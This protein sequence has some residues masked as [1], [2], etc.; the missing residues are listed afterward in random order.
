MVAS[1]F[2]PRFVPIDFLL[3]ASCLWPARATQPVAHG[4]RPAAHAA[5][6][7]TQAESRVLGY[8]LSGLSNKE[9]AGR[10]G[11]AEPT[12]K[13]QVAAIL[14]KHRVPSRSRLIA[15]VSQGAGDA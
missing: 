6:G 3:G 15:L 8:V 2:S 1:R 5:A 14:R 9:I 4:A 10:L 12:I 7:L 11:R 13:N